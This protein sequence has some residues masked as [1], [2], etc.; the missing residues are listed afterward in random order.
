[1]NKNELRHA[2]CSRHYIAQGSDTVTTQIT[3]H[4]IK[5]LVGNYTHDVSPEDAAAFFALRP[6]A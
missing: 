1:L 5:M 4:S 3:G 2:F 6:V